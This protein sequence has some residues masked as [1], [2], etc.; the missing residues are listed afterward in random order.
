MIKIAAAVSGAALLAGA[1]VLLPGMTPMVAAGPSLNVAALNATP[2]DA[3]PAPSRVNLQTKGDRLD[4]LIIGP[5]CSE[6]AWPYYEPSCIRGD[7]ARKP[8]RIVTTDRLPA[9]IRF[10]TSN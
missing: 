5:G 10:A 6:Q 2:L 8:V 1:I 7:S 3:G 9:S 4:I